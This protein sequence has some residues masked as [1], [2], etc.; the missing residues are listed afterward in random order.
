MKEL[1]EVQ[2][3]PVM[4]RARP[5]SRF[6]KVVI[7]LSAALTLPLFLPSYLTRHEHV[8]QVVRSPNTVDPAGEWKDD[9]WPLRP[10]TPWDI[11][12]DFPYPRKLEYDVTEGTWMRLDV[13]PK[14]GDI[15]FDMLGDLYCLPGSAYSSDTTSRT[16][17]R[18]VLLG[19]P[20]D[21]DPHF[22]PDGE[23]LVFRSDAELG[24]ENIWITEW[25]GCNE[26]DV[27]PQD[28]QGALMYALQ[29]QLDDEDA[30][31]Q[32]VRETTEVKRHR[33]IREG[34]LNGEFS[35]VPLLHFLTPI[36]SP[37]GY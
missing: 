17:A 11:S 16:R 9:V 6:F 14:T 5:R 30:L 19:I 18:P 24:V 36:C 4:D 33:L 21:S 13:H 25:K 2:L 27:R 34:R 22:S 28:A 29:H 26:M 31:A 7:L 12:T 20:H 35:I 1:P 8:L 37:E 15:V 23:K 3:Q 32:G 10:P